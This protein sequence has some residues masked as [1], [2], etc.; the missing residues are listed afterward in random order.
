MKY[1][2]FHGHGAQLFDLS[3]DRG[4]WHNLCGR[5]EYRGIERELKGLIL[6]QFDP[7]AIERELRASLQRRFLLRDAMK[8]AG[9]DWMYRPPAR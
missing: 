4:E 3:Q 5:P 6:E 7:D 2:Y 8:R 9:V 1:S